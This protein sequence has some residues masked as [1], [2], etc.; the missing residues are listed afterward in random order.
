MRTTIQTLLF[1]SILY[2]SKSNAQDDWKAGLFTEAKQLPIISQG[3]HIDVL[4]GSA[5]IEYVQF[6]KNDGPAIAQADYY[7]DLPASITLEEFGFWNS[8]QYLRAEVKERSVAERAH[9]IAAR[10]NRPTA[11]VKQDGNIKHFSIYPVQANETK[12]IR[13][14][15]RADVTMFMGQSSFSV[16]IQRFLGQRD[17]LTPVSVNLN[18]TEAVSQIDVRELSEVNGVKSELDTRSAFRSIE[19]L[20]QERS[21][22]ESRLLFSSARRVQVLWKEKQNELM[23]SGR[24]VRLPDSSHAIEVTSVLPANFRH[25]DEPRLLHVLLDQSYSMRRRYNSVRQVLKHFQRFKD[26]SVKL[27]LIG[28]DFEEVDL[29]SS[30]I[31]SESFS[32]QLSESN[33]DDFL[34][35]L[36]G[37]ACSKASVQCLVITDPQTSGIAKSTQSEIP[38]LILADSHELEWAGKSIQSSHLVFSYEIDQVSLVLRSIDELVRPSFQI[39]SVAQGMQTLEPVGFQSRVLTAGSMNKL[40]L[41]GNG[42]EEV[43]V[44]FQHDDKVVIRKVDIFEQ[45]LFSKNATRIRKAYF[46]HKINRWMHDFKKNQNSELK[47]KIIEVGVREQIPT[48]FTSM[49]VE[50]PSTSLYAIKP[51]DPTLSVPFEYGLKEVVAVYPFGETRR[52]KFDFVSQKFYDRFLVPRFWPDNVYKIDVIKYFENG[53]I[54]KDK[55]YYKI[56]NVRP[57]AIVRV[58][59][60]KQ[61]LVVDTS[62]QTYDVSTVEVRTA[63]REVYELVPLGQQW[64]IDLKLVQGRF[65]VVLRDRAGNRSVIRA[66]YWKGVLSI[67]SERSKASPV[68]TE[69]NRSRGEVSSTP[70]N[71]VLVVTNNKAIFQA[72]N[73]RY[74][75]PYDGF[76]PRSLRVSSHLV[77]SKHKLVF[78]TEGGDIVLVE[79]HRNDEMCTATPIDQGI[80]E[81]P[82]TGITDLPSGRV[83]VSVLGKGLF[84]INRKNEFEKSKFHVGTRFITAMQRAGKDILVGTARRGLW[85]IVGSRAIRT[86]FSGNSIYGIESVKG[87]L[88]VQSS[89]GTYQ[90][91]RRDRYRQM[92]MKRAY[93]WSASRAISSGILHHGHLFL[94]SFDTGLKVTEEGREQVIEHSERPK[95]NYVNQ[96]AVFN[97]NVWMATEGGLF[98]IILNGSNN[99]TRRVLDGAVYGLASS[100]Q[101]LAVAYGKGVLVIAKDGEKKAVGFQAGIGE[102]RFGTVQWHDGDL[103]AGG[104]DGLYRFAK[105]GAQKISSVNGYSGGWVTALLSSGSTLYIGTY[106]D[107]VYEF[108]GETA[109]QHIDLKSQWV[110]PHALGWSEGQLFVGG[111]GMPGVLVKKSGVAE[112]LPIPV[113]DTNGFIFENGRVQALTSDGRFDYRAREMKVNLGAFPALRA[114]ADVVESA[115]SPR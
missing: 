18:T 86:R 23:V 98:E 26:T 82:V 104:L 2:P 78:G 15:L 99:Y 29:N 100:D 25:S 66:K 40:L 109:R 59:K 54:E 50:A 68:L 108:S 5:R 32:S 53:R 16:P 17:V 97:D 73:Q 9:K 80:N 48:V 71:R 69:L 12:K 63:S 91:V 27:H 62:E 84:E 7:L 93:R 45:S 115:S 34:M 28:R 21:P 31:S 24:S 70:D 52:M 79:C 22:K 19:F 58:D 88:I 60:K 81:Y 113:R 6:F 42:E 85:R 33:W 56:D 75:F 35:Y 20:Q 114:V 96:L 110:P 1:L 10:S 3:V 76:T 67:D 95:D 90:R 14:V 47:T 36:N 44:Q 107:G 112:L 61:L 74:S 4:D 105:G 49:Q 38:V 92:T 72:K 94:G 11:I 41:T 83:L 46:R 51:G 89:R 37:L 8:G 64:V 87:R 43:T 103:F 13:V 106:E 101:G 77:L 65:H 111:L 55:A 57:N 39:S 30:T 102:P